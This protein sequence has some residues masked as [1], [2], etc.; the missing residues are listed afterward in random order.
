MTFPEQTDLTTV[1][2]AAYVAAGGTLISEAEWPRYLAEANRLIS[3]ITFGN[4]ALATD[5]TII[6]KVTDATF[7]VADAIYR[8]TTGIASEKIGSYSV[9][10]K[11]G[12]DNPYTV[13]RNALSGTGLTYAGIA[14]PANGPTMTEV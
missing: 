3:D 10:Y 11:D 1:S 6:A 2:Y 7:R 13:A 9:S 12:V 4:A 8:D 14:V 5:A